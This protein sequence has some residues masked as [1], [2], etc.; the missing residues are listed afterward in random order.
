MSDHPTPID[1]DFWTFP[2]QIAARTMWA[3]CRGEPLDGQTAVAH[4]L[5]NR[6]ASGRWGA[7]LATVC[8]APLQFSCWN[9]SDP[10]RLRMVALA[11][12]DPALA[13]MFSILKNAERAAKDPTGGAMFYFSDSMIV[14]PKWAA[15]MHFITKI[16]HHQFYREK[17]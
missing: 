3:E 17:P 1:P 16:G 15:G 12:D 11:D 4:V 10:Q 5:L 14:P 6:K 7:S 8:V 13:H 9:A 2:Y